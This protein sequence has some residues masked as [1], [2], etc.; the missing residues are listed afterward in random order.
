[1]DNRFLLKHQARYNLRNICIRTFKYLFSLIV[2]LYSI[3]GYS[4]M[5]KGGA[6]RNYFKEAEEVV[7][8]KD[9]KNPDYLKF[10]VET[11]IKYEN[12]N[13]WLTTNYKISQNF[14]NRLISTETDEF[15]IKHIRFQQCYNNV[16]VKGSMFIIHV[17]DNKVVSVNGNILSDVN[18][19]NTKNISSSYSVKKA[20]AGVGAEQY[21]WQDK[22]E[23]SSLKTLK[24]DR[25]ATYYPDAK[26]ELV[27]TNSGYKYAYKV[28][29]YS[30][31]PLA[32]QTVFVDAS[33][34]SII[35]S[36]NKLKDLTLTGIA[37]TKYYGTK[38]ITT[39]IY[40]GAYTLR[41]ATRGEGIETY[42][43]NCGNNYAF[44]VDFTDVD[45]YWNNINT[46]QDEAAT[47]VHWATEKTYDYFKTFH[48]RNSYNNNGIKVLSY[49]HFHTGF[50]NAFWD[51]YRITYGDGD[52]TNN[53]Q[54]LTTL[55]ICG[56]EFT[57]A[58]ADYTAN[59]DYS[60]EPGTIEEGFAD[61]FGTCI[62]FYANPSNANWTIG[63]DMGSILRSLSNPKS[64]NNPDT[65]L[66]QYWG[67]DIH[68]NST[69]MSHWFYLVANGGQGV[70]D[71]NHSYNISGLGIVKAAKI[72]YR[73]LSAY[74]TSTSD[75]QA[76]CTYSKLAAADL[77]GQCSP[78]VIAVTNS[79]YAVGLGNSINTPPVAINFNADITSNCTSP[80]IVSFQN[81]T[82][83]ALSYLWDFGDG[84]TST[85]QNPSHTYTQD[86]HY[87]VTLSVDAADCGI[88]SAIK[89]NYINLSP[90]S[91][92]I[93]TMTNGI[94]TVNAAQT[95]CYGI[96]NGAGLGT[97]YTNNINSIVTI[98]PTDGSKV[99]LNFS[100]FDLENGHDYLYI[101]DGPDT[102]SS[103]IGSYTGNNLPNGG[104][105]SASQNKLTLRFITDDSITGTGFKLTWQCKNKPLNPF[106]EFSSADTNTCSGYVNFHDFTTNSP[107]AWFWIF[108]DG[109]FS[110]EQNPSHLYSDNGNYSVTLIAANI[111]GF[112]TITRANYI[113]VAKSGLPVIQ[114]FNLCDSGSAMLR[115]LSLN[116]DEYL[117]YNNQSGGSAFYSGSIYYTPVL[118]N[119]TNY[120]V[121][122]V[123]YGPLKYIARN[124][125]AGAG[126]YDNNP[127]D[128][129]LV[130][131]ANN[132]FKL[133]S[134]KVYAQSSGFRTVQLKDSLGNIL[135]AADVFINQGESRITLDFNIPFAEKLQLLCLGNSGLYFNTNNLTNDL[136]YDELNISSEFNN[137]YNYFYSW[138]I[139]P[140]T[141]VTNRKE[142]V[143]T[144]NSCA[145]VGEFVDEE[146]ISVYPNPAESKVNIKLP[147][148]SCGEYS[149]K[150]TD[151]S[152]RLIK[153]EL[154]QTGSYGDISTLDVGNLQSGLY[155][156]E[157]T[158]NTNRF[159]QKLEVK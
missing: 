104:S 77:Y 10:S 144:V 128:G 147:A 15:G 60:G 103:L 12:I 79:W 149:M 58:V 115:I 11:R 148:E 93:Y 42:D 27:K 44:S 53:F 154:L 130:F 119:T 124:D 135:Q 70:N 25:N 137:G 106:A 145:G 1:M 117:W 95:C 127:A 87:N 3:A 132:P 109:S 55:D 56:H 112:D 34:G 85:D 28:E 39:S 2:V 131:N 84:S 75:F 71:L 82:T 94:N 37:L 5:F 69:V 97:T 88:I 57:H 18:I 41:D 114:N 17:E 98:E 30:K 125:S 155:I 140:V 136:N 31:K 48:N 113:K 7:F 47:D 92:S 141:C 19:V 101:Y 32:L 62:E 152:G 118:H 121:E 8:V 91:S 86:G 26:L 107:E 100:S 52:A 146:G 54:P 102:N 13:L 123:N 138:E 108:G 134:V 157:I 49:V 74:L 24:S 66:G 9:S 46:Q 110:T 78:E 142:A 133:K 4:Q 73:T 89:H 72:A 126:A 16:P 90:S 122:G 116:S 23:E 159:I 14:S 22:N 50:K 81:T 83:N 51:G 150:L 139:K 63:E 6:A 20:L 36:E 40:N 156:I 29:V 99:I 67:T 153:N 76:V 64:L 38:S 120:F 68:Q 43:M 45:N 21:M 96:I 59:F 35:Y 158:N 65:Y 111:F 129:G 33:T 143:A 80:L 151:L 105:L 61:I